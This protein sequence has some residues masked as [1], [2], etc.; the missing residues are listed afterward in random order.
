MFKVIG[1]SSRKGKAITQLQQAKTVPVAGAAANT[2]IAVAGIGLKDEITSV[3]E[4]DFAGSAINDRTSEAS[5]TSAGNIQLSTTD[6]T[7]KTLLV[8]YAPWQE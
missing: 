5:V 6:T 8:A 1:D 2:N 3:M 7:G 4:V